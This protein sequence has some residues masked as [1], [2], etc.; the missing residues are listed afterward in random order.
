M[1]THLVSILMISAITNDVKQTNQN[2]WIIAYA[3]TFYEMFY[4]RNLA[5]SRDFMMWQRKK[6]TWKIDPRTFDLHERNNKNKIK[7]V[8]YVHTH[9]GHHIWLRKTDKLRFYF[10]L[11]NFNWKINCF[12]YFS[13]F[14]S[15][16][17]NQLWETVSIF[18]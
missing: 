9:D 16:T 11:P 13:S 7:I 8:V 17:F 3:H 14:S 4:I 2:H 5:N 12:V 18:N 10:Q 15:F 6:N 1:L